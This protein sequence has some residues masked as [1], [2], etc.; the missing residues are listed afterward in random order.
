MKKILL[1]IFALSII[2][3]P[4]LGYAKK[5]MN[6]PIEIYGRT[7]LRDV[8]VISNSYGFIVHGKLIL[9]DSKISAPV[10]AK[11][12]G[13]GSVYLQNDY[14]NCELGVKYAQAPIGDV[15]INN[16]FTGRISNASDFSSRMPG[17]GSPFPFMP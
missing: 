15:M 10:G 7:T 5:T 11:V 14:F 17:T 8:H 12:Y 9:I 4:A 3:S 1:I 2:L 16:T 13:F 6:G